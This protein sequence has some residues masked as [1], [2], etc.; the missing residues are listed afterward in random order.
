MQS[1][2]PQPSFSNRRRLQIG[3]HVLAS[4]LA[5][6]AI[7]IMVNYLAAHH[8]NRHRLSSAD[9]NELSP[10]TLRM[11]NSLTNTVKVIVFF[12]KQDPSSMF[13]Q[14]SSLLKE[15]ELASPRLKVEYVDYNHN[16]GQAQFIKD[17]YK[18]FSPGLDEE[19]SQRNL[20][21]FDSG[22]RPP[23][24]VFEKELADYD[25]SGLLSGEG[26]QIK[27]STFKGE[28]LFTS[29]ILNVT[30]AKR[31][32]AY[33]V[34]GHGEHSF[35][36][37]NELD[38]YSKLAAV[39]QQMNMDLN[40]LSLLESSV[41]EDCQL[42]IIAGAQEKYQREE[43]ERLESYLNNDGRALILMRN[44]FWGHGLEN[45]LTRWGVQ[46]GSELVFH[47][48]SNRGGPSPNG[49]NVEFTIITTNFPTPGH[50]IAKPLLA[51]RLQLGVAWSVDRQANIKRDADSPK[52]DVLVAS[53]PHGVAT[54]NF[55]ENKPTPSIL[56]RRGAIPLVV[57]LEKGGVQGISAERGSTRVVVT[58]DSSFLANN[59]IDSAAN[60]DFAVLAVNWL[61]DRSHL[62]GGIGPRA[63]K[64]YK[65]V[66]TYNEL[67]AVRW[68]L[69][70]V[71]PG[72]VFSLGMLVWF[73]RRS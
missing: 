20:V 24:I 60:Q 37:D 34:E 23:K 49:E 22:N 73:R 62:M 59:L 8:Y 63:I 47:T 35:A 52:V 5:A 2:P 26:R 36:S 56:D 12:D 10:L 72:A 64:E 16:P 13:S 9:R 50:P 1:P 25:L 66:M 71:F 61:L 6:L 19:V 46:I 15:Y 45:L 42:L 48:K 54:S 30:D 67:M 4:V 57:A 18:L 58:G 51:S 68:L 69:L 31:I 53:G 65:L 39:L 3:L 44:S 14:V 32:R 43:L 55:P 17:R 28:L 11:L 33:Y 41:P 70:A 40:P 38:G 21:I 7:V 29:A 27:R